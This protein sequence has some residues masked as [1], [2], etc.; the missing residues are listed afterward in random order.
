[1][2]FTLEI[3][4]ASLSSAQLKIMSFKMRRIITNPKVRKG[5]DVVK[6]AVKPYVKEAREIFDNA[7]HHAVALEVVFWFPFPK[8]GTKAEKAARVGGQPV[9]SAL[10]GDADNR[11]KA[12]QDALK[13][14][15]CFADDRYVSTL[16]VR[17]RYTRSVPR[18][19][20]RIE[21]DEGGYGEGE[22]RL[23]EEPPEQPPSLF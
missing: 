13:D 19:D 8:S 22:F 14:A 3:N 17:K 1:M 9:V 4:P 7:A 15:G 16:V 5:M 11:V 6:K 10:Y 20:V 2:K 21:S 18:I 12:F 23:K